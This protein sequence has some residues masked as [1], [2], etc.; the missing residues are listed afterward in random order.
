M[1]QP[2]E[3][4]PYAV[5]EHSIALGTVECINGEPD[6]IWPRSEL[7]DASYII[8]VILQSFLLI[9]EAIH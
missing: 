3:T 5:I 4:L 2:Y 6:I 7:H 1:T 9:F 8:K